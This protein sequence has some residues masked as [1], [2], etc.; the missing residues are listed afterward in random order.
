MHKPLI[1][2]LITVAA[3]FALGMS[4]APGLLLDYAIAEL[5]TPA[6]LAGLPL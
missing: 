3:A 1:A 5:G 2:L 4:G 6:A